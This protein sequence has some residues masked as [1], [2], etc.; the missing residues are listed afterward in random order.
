[1]E[2][3]RV[4]KKES[5]DLLAADAVEN[6]SLTQKLGKISAGVWQS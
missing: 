4:V 3:S 6:A 5:E 1:M 2:F